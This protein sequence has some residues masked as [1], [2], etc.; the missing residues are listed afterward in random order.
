MNTSKTLRTTLLCALI[1]W[2][3]ATPK[4]AVAEPDS[5]ASPATAPEKAQLPHH[6]LQSRG[7]VYDVGLH[8]TPETLSIEKYNPELVEFDM[9]AIAG[10][11]HA[12]TVR[13]EGEEIRRLVDASTAAHRAGLKV[14]FNPWKMGA[15]G[16]E[17]VSYMAEA[18]AAAERLRLQGVDIV[19]VAGCEYTIFCKGALPGDAF[20]DRLSA[21]MKAIQTSMETKAVSR[22]LES[23]SARL[24]E[25]LARAVAG[26]RQR[27]KG[28][29]TYASGP[30]ESIDW[31]IFD[32]VGVDHYRNGETEETY[33]AGLERYRL[34]K[35]LF[36]MEVGSCTYEGAGA[37]GAGGF[38]ILQGTN[39]DGT[40]K[41]AGGTPPTRSEREQA[42]YVETQVRVLNKAGVDGVFIYV[43]AF[44]LY[45]YD[46]K[47]IDLD[48][49]SFAIVRS[50]PKHDPRSNQIPSWEKKESYR[51]LAA[52][53]GELARKL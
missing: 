13:I 38:M 50:F 7:V 41:Y 39:P 28:P 1:V 2:T 22:E 24:N 31:S 19:F 33:I 15:D 4:A 30:W 6:D 34:G 5:A 18:A 3:L 25:I 37:R 43:F 42:D 53:Y 48:M 51:R 49:T 16:E 20:N 23:A 17:T 36:V 35:P 8:F 29:V 52:V 21:L 32:I 9:R 12:N 10:E 45:P 46:E 44:P 47:G 14:F 27:F 11:L 40:P 26:I